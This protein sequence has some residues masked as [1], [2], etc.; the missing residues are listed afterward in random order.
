MDSVKTLL[1]TDEKYHPGAPGQNPA[2]KSWGES[3]PLAIQAALQVHG[4]PLCVHNTG[5]RSVS[6]SL[7]ELTIH[8]HFDQPFKVKPFIRLDSSQSGTGFLKGQRIDLATVSVSTR[9]SV[10]K[11]GSTFKIRGPWTTLQQIYQAEH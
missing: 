9:G 3:L 4:A 1:V 7:R 2:W 6:L 5:R 10:I 8:E 11:E